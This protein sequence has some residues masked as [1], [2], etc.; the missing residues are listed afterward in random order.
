MTRFRLT[1]CVA[2][3]VFGLSGTAA[4]AGPPYRPYFPPTPAPMLLTKIDTRPSYGP[5]RVPQVR[6]PDLRYQSAP[7]VAPPPPRVRVIRRY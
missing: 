7:R 3:L 6:T 4:T 2:S 1:C 5:V